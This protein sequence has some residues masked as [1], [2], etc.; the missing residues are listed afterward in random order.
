MASKM[1]QKKTVVILSILMSL[2]LLLTLPVT[3]V[4][5]SSY[6][7]EGAG[8][9]DPKTKLKLYEEAKEAAEKTLG[10]S[11]DYS[12]AYDS[13][14][15]VHQDPAVFE[16]NFVLTPAQKEI[17]IKRCLEGT[18]LLTDDMSDLEKYYMLALW[19]NYSVKYDSEFWPGGYDFDYYSHQWD[20]YGILEEH[21]GV[22]AGIAV[23]YAVLCHAADLPCKFVRCDK[24]LDHTINHIPD[25]NGHSY[26]IDVTENSFFMSKDSSW[27]FEPIDLS[28]S[29]I[30][31]A[32]RPSDGSFE[33]GDDESGQP[34]NI[35]DYYTGKT[36]EGP[37]EYVPFE[38]WYNEYALHQGTDKAFC[39]EYEENGSGR[40]STQEGYKHASY[41]EFKNYPAQPYGSRKNGITDIWFLNDFYQEPVT[42]KGKIENK[43][44]DEQLLIIDEIKKNYDCDTEGKSKEDVEA[45]LSDAIRSDISS[46]NYFPSYIND[47]VVAEKT[48]L[49]EGTDYDVSVEYDDSRHEATVTIQGKGTYQGECRFTVKVNTALVTKAPIRNSYLEYNGSVQEL[50]DSNNPGEAEYGTILYAIGTK[51]GPTEEFSS[52]IP[53]A[54]NAGAY[55][56]W[57][58]AVGDENHYDSEE[59]RI[60]QPALLHPLVTFVIEEN[61]TVRVGEKVKL[62]PELAPEL[63][64]TFFY[65]SLDEDI[66]TV[67]AD[68]TVTGIAEGDVMIRISAT[69]KE[70]GP[71]YAEPYDGYVT[72]T[73]IP[74]EAQKPDAVGYQNVSGDGNVWYRGSR[75]TSDFVFKRSVDDAAAIDHFTGIRVDGEPVDEAKYTKKSGS[76]VIKL[77][78]TYL[79]TL[80]LGEHTLEAQF[81]DGSASARF[82]VAVKA[83]GDGTESKTGDGTGAR[84]ADGTGVRTG[85]GSNILL[86]IMLMTASLLAGV[87]IVVLNRRKTNSK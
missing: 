39:K 19:E 25:I 58:K 14:T 26:Y 7:P 17:A 63:A 18:A 45:A 10:E 85:D 16:K 11:S 82:T 44:L 40:R 62:A 60:L 34:A 48:P 27:S 76:V 38:Q 31:E 53:M 23:T 2:A 30:D 57:Y 28:F 70:E 8:K 9:E 77:K 56:I 3:S 65:E 47:E 42:I 43:E 84:T 71:N 74:K 13:G 1:G 32:D 37:F 67:S 33:Y 29:G 66:A 55:Y 41:T 81:N 86:W 83:A 80:A 52:V 12:S 51:D 15:G 72:I 24:Y 69:P 22:C 61:K 5:A 36:G 50:L 87:L 78:P 46:V 21:L 49:T 79:E 73:V 4:F 6:E 59:Q 54:T 20:V 68:G 64:A 75:A 35:K